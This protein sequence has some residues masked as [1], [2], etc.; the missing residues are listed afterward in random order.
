MAMNQH[1][2]MAMGKMASSTNKST[3]AADEY[4]SCGKVS[5]HKAMSS[6]GITKMGM[7]RK[8]V[9]GKKSSS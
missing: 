8:G 9:P 3:I 5:G 1:K 6:S 4:A 2:K 7:A